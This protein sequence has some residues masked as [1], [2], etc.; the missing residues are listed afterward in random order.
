MGFY[1]QPEE[2][3]ADAVARIIGEL[4]DKVHRDLKEP[5]EGQDAAIHE[6]RKSMKKLRAMLRL[7]RPVIRKKAFVSADRAVRDFARQL[8]GARDSAV[9]L[10]T[11]DE[12]MA[13]YSAFL[14]ESTLLPIRQ[15]LATRHQLAMEQQQ[16]GLDFA[17]LKSKFD[18]LDEH[19]SR[20]DLGEFTNKILLDSAQESYRE[21]RAALASL[22][23]DPSTEHGHALRKQVKY[24]WYQIRMFQK[25]D[26][27][28][29]RQQIQ[30]L[31]EL[32]EMLGR[33][34]DLAL[35]G[36]T[37]QGDPGICCNAIR[38]EIVSGLIETRRIAI[39]SAA[40]RL[41]DRIYAQK[42]RRFASGLRNSVASLL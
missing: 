26:T 23:V 10:A 13:H 9:V 19:F 32:G 5:Q 8:G 34:H 6:V 38:C 16:A 14:N 27:A 33:D 35:L 2:S 7:V 24:L 42:P 17:T 18:D 4:L 39:L 25:A 22:H 3:S 31:D 40:L 20:L 15:A 37:L 1:L 41:A 36:E 30:E 28:Q 29:I 12:L 21:C 11:F